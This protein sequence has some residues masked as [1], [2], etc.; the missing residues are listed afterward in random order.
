MPHLSPNLVA[1]LGLMW[2][3]VVAEVLHRWVEMPANRAVRRW[4]KRESSR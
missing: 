3:F 4:E 1:V 2:T